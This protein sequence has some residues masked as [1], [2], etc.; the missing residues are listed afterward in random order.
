VS[1][2]LPTGGATWAERDRML[3]KAYRAVVARVVDGRL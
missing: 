3:A 2:H 1:A